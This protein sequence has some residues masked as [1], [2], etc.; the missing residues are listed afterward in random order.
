MCGATCCAGDVAGGE[1]GGHVYSVF[2][3]CAGATIET[4]R[5]C[6][7]SL[8]GEDGEDGEDACS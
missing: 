6:E 8:S 4:E 5:L 7:A 2:V 3:Y 1:E